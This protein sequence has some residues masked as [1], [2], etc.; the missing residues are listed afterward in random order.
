MGCYLQKFRYV[1]SKEL[2]DA[3]NCQRCLPQKSPPMLE[4]RQILSTRMDLRYI[5]TVLV[6][7]A[8][9]NAPEASTVYPQEADLH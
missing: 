1:D 9:A 7:I 5:R 8:V 2:V 6:Y 3:H 4:G